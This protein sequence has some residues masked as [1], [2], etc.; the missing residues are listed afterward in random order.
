M[1]GLVSSTPQT[2]AI[3]EAKPLGVMEQLVNK[4][5]RLNEQVAEVEAT[6]AMFQKHPEFEQCLTQLSRCGIYR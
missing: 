4:R 3:S 2:C 6:I 5:D 1:S